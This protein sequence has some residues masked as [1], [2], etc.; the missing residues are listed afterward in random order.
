MII[1]S[2][3]TIIHSKQ[4]IISKFSLICLIFF[5]FNEHSKTK[6]YGTIQSM[7]VVVG[8][9]RAKALIRHK[10]LGGIVDIWAK[11]GARFKD[12]GSMV[13][14][15]YFLHHG[16]Q[17][18]Y[19]DCT[20]YYIL[21]GICEVAQKL[22][23]NKDKYEEVICSET[24][25]QIVERIKHSILELHT[26]IKDLG[27]VPIFST[28]CPMNLIQWNMLRHA[29]NKTT[30]LEFTKHYDEMQ[31][32]LN[33]SITLIN[34]FIINLNTSSKVKTPMTHRCVQ[35]N[36]K[37]GKKNWRLYKLSDGCHFSKGLS[38]E[39]AMSLKHAITLNRQ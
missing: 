12:M 15:H 7:N 38:D 39:I 28:I 19:D 22:K 17:P 9:S 3:Y 8:D 10:H 24:P 29:Q 14:E 5:R 4:N 21:G 6:L 31:T 26:Q 32:S 35:H 20:H 16:G 1:H 34:E 27:A 13:N 18:L 33:E 23:S 25:N 30:R 37:N 2:S 11:P 36:R